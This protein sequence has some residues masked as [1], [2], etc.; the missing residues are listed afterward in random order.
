MHSRTIVLAFFAA[1]SLAAPA[2]VAAPERF[3]LSRADLISMVAALEPASIAK[4]WG[5][6]GECSPGGYH[7]CW[8]CND[9][10]GFCWYESVK[11]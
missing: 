1:L 10:N 5:G 6:C 2:P 7:T 3:Q 4:R 11:C 8:E 9:L